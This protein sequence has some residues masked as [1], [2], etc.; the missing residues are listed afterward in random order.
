MFNA[1]KFNQIRFNS[2]LL[3]LALIISVLDSVTV[4]E[5]AD[6][7][8]RRGRIYFPDNSRFLRKVDIST[9][10]QKYKK[11]SKIYR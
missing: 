3:D 8:I 11:K 2:P 1:G 4:G 7:W 10:T 5:L 6:I 9:P